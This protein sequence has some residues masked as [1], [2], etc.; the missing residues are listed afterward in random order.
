M[1]KNSENDSRVDNVI[2][3]TMNFIRVVPFQGVAGGG[4]N[5]ATVPDVTL[6]R[7]SKIHS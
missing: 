1:Y 7:A 4:G 6:Q 5:V 2:V 3:K